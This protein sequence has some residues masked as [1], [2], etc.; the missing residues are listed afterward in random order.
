M[1]TALTHDELTLHL[2]A[3]GVIVL[4]QQAAQGQT[5]FPYPDALQR[6]LD[7]LTVAA[8]RRHATPPQGV[9]DL[10][11]WCRAPISA[12]PL[13]LPAGMLDGDETLLIDH[14][15]SSTCD[16][17][18]CANPDAEAELTERRV[19]QRVFDLCSH[20][21]D[22]AAYVAFRSLLITSPA[23]TALELQQHCIRPELLRL[24]DVLR[25]S[26][27]P[28]PSAWATN[29]VVTCCAHCHNILVPLAA[30]GYVCETE[31][32]RHERGTL[33]GRRIPAHEKPVW[34]VRGLRRFVAAPGRAEQRLAQAVTKLGLGVELWPALDRYDLRITLP[35]STVWAVDVKDWANPFLL[36]RKLQPLPVE[37]PW[38]RAFVVV[39]DYRLKQRR[40]YVRALRQACVN[41]SFTITSER[42]LLSLLKKHM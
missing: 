8:L 12:W 30:G 20:A 25:D 31:T 38:N 22:T 14:H 24:S 1:A 28:A 21:N 10:L 37:P 4:T 41:R 7:R 34:L 26:Y 9:P 32:C 13:D 29:S 42:E 16:D 23:M 35:D 36:A 5:L 27:Q 15:P 33:L 39:P 17:W 6:G 2:I 18:A 11:A 19:M 3:T 40:D